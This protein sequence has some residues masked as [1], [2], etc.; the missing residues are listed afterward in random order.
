VVSKRA[1]SF[2]P[3]WPVENVDEGQK[4]ELASDNARASKAGFDSFFLNF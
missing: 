4:P 1:G 2:Y 3:I